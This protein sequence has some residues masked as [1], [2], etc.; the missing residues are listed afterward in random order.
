MKRISL[1]IVLVCCMLSLAAQKHEYVFHGDSMEIVVNCQSGKPTISDFATAF[2]N[3][4]Q[5]EFFARV[6]KDWKRYQQ[7]KPLDKNISL[8][9][10][11]KNGYWEHVVIDTEENAK[12]TTE[13]CYWNCKDGLQKI[14]AVSVR[15]EIGKELGWDE[16]V[17]ERFFVYDNQKK[18]M[19]EILPEDIGALYD[20]ECLRAFYLPRRGKNIQVSVQCVDEKWIDVLKWNG[21]E[22]Y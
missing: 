5:E 9:V 1:I 18:T 2:L 11:K 7:G 15:M 3:S 17:G 13:M 19:R 8:L 22:F 14:V 4:A 12:N 20:G 21:F 10:D 16:H 6:A